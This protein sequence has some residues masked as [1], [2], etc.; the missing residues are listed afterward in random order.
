MNS[1]I[2]SEPGRNH[3]I[4]VH[5]NETGGGQTYSQLSAK[6]PA[7]HTLIPGALVVILGVIHL[8]QGNVSAAPMTASHL[9]PEWTGIA[10][11]VLIMNNFLA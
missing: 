10:S 7:E 9:L 11:L 4:A 1:L 6:S 5:L 2:I 8:A 3:F